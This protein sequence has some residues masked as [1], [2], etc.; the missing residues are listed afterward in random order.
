MTSLRSVLLKHAGALPAP[1]D[2]LGSADEPSIQV[3]P[4]PILD[5]DKLGRDLSVVNKGNNRYFFI[6][7]S[8]VLTLFAVSVGVVLTN[9]N[10]PDIIKVVMAAF[11]ISSAGLITMMIKLWRE[12][13][14]TE[15]MILLAIN[16]DS[17]TLKTII[18]ILA[19]RL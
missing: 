19:K 15:L 5:R 14:N 4:V 6:C 11:G 12:K 10:K 13:S 3:T 7:V 1:K 17:D 18:A 9:L 8:M 2:S 16:M